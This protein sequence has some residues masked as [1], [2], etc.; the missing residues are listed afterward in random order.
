MCAKVRNFAKFAMPYCLYHA[1]ADCQQ[2]TKYD[3]SGCFL[4]NYQCCLEVNY[5][6]VLSERVLL[7]KVVLVQAVQ[8]QIWMQTISWKIT[9]TRVVF[10]VINFNPDKIHTLESQ[11]NLITVM[12]MSRSTLN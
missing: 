4:L 8:T 9:V 5:K 12:W 6:Q 10:K 2:S 7:R 1:D 3:V 11:A